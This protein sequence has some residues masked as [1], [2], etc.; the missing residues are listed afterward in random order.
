[1]TGHTTIMSSAQHRPARRHPALSVAPV[2]DATSTHPLLD[3]QRT[4]GN[5]GVV[6]L[7]RRNRQ[8]VQRSLLDDRVAEADRKNLRVLTSEG[9]SAMDADA[10]K[11]AFTGKDRTSIPAQQVTI[12]P[13]IPAKVR[14]GLE[15][16]AGD[17]F[18]AS[19]FTWNTITHVALDLRPFGGPNAVFR[20]TAVQRTAAPRTEVLIEQVGTRSAPLDA[21]GIKA[22]EARFQRFDFK[23]GT[24]FGSTQSQ[25]DLYTALARVP[26]AVLERV[27]GVTFSRRLATAGDRNEAGHYDP[28][29]HTITLF[30]SSQTDLFNSV[31]AGASSHFTFVITHEVSHAVDF[32]RFT[33]ARR[34]RDDLA[35]QLKQARLDARRVDPNEPVDL[36]GEGRAP[37]RNADRI[38]QLE[39]DLNRAQTEFDAAAA[40]LNT[41]ASQHSKSRAYADAKGR[42]ISTYGGT[43]VVENFAES[44]SLFILDPDL[45]KSIRPQAFAYFQRNWG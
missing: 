22:Q 37:S 21:K 24:D 6:A 45:L 26:D 39:Q 13:G 34:K 8:V 20:F 27:R 40:G 11:A 31:D 2:R 3:L 4:V 5:R 43:D 16:L 14:P 33:E 35:A 12:D 1:M 38:R 17:M 28:N 44:M 25:N 15:S 23:F 7:L 10:I 30:G 36:R 41:G 32:Q 19:S 18:S 29:T 9:V 42:A